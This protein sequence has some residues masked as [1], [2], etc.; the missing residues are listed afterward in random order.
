MKA[1]GRRPRAFIVSRLPARGGGG[2]EGG[3]Y[4]RCL[5]TPPVHRVT[6]VFREVKPT[7]DSTGAQNLYLTKREAAR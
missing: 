3:T 6:E 1:R 7:P 4:R 2:G 5:D